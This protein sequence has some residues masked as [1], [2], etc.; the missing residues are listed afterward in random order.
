MLV[1]GGCFKINACLGDRAMY[2]ILWLY[3]TPKLPSGRP[4][5]TL[6]SVINPLSGGIPLTFGIRLMVVV[7]AMGMDMVMA[8]AMDRSVAYQS[9]LFSD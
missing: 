2:K 5:T 6:L 7:M 9:L 8:T 1:V 4:T 3:R